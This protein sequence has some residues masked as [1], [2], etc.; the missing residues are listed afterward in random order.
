MTENNIKE[1]IVQQLNEQVNHIKD[2]SK[3]V[4]QKVFIATTTTNKKYVIKHPQKNEMIFRE[5]FACNML[6]NKIPVPEI[7]HSTNEYV[8]E[9]YINGNDLNE[10]TLTETE[11]EK[12]YTQLGEILAI[13][14]SHKTEAYGAIMP[15]GKGKHS[16]LKNFSLYN[17][18]T[19]NKLRKAYLSSGET[20]QLQIFF[21]K[22]E[23]YFNNTTSVLLHY[24]FID[25]NIR[26]N[27]NS[28]SGI[29]DFGDLAAGCSALDFAWIYIHHYNKKAFN[30]IL[31]GYAKEVDINEIKFFAACNL[32]WFIT[33][34]KTKNVALQKLN[35]LNNIVGF[36]SSFKLFS[37][38]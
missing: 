31:K 1:I 23:H 15:N 30:Y 27:N 13:I 32:V 21:E 25:S 2:C 9:S 35:M 5:V 22:N 17:E 26:I 33:Y 8:I 29:I 20:K 7:I 6:K 12:I 3:G 11:E 36:K 16:N 19:L 4:E 24:D 37:K 14:H 28:V 38:W 34:E 10:I 18:H